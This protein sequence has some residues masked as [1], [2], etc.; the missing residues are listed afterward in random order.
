MN[1]SSKEVLKINKLN[2]I[3]SNSS[4]YVLTG[5]DLKM[6]SGD[7][8]ALVG[9]SGCGKSTVAKAV[10][11]LLPDGSACYGE[12][13]LNGKNILKLDNIS[14]QTIRGKEVGLIFQD[15]MSRLNPL[16]TIGDHLVDT[17]RAHEHSLSVNYL[18]KRA[19]DLLEKVGINPVRFNSFP[20]EFSGGMRQRLAI[21]LAI[22]LRP[23]L[24]I[25]DEPTTSLDTI[26]ADQIMS[27]LSLLCDEIGTAL[28][29]ISHDLSMAYK[30]CNEIAIL[31]CG[32]IVESGNIK[33][34]ISDPKTDIAQ[35][36][37]H[38][39]RILE[40]SEREVINKSTVL[41]RVNR[42]RL[43]LIHI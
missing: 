27:E 7:R 23:P 11:Q 3:Y 30:W 10:M 14:M 39:G 16:M 29:L 42:L 37:V 31:D 1:N 9:S 41:L 21:A 35:R 34:I 12:I 25:A 2:A 40:G 4:S 15:P 43:S 26:V 22:C 36:L 20:H 17:L 13:F 8:L 18:V 24:I 28:L 6:N 19:K 33:Q 32:K 5:L 38:S